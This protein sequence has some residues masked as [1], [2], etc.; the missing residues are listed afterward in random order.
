MWSSCSASSSFTQKNSSNKSKVWSPK[1]NSWRLRKSICLIW[2]RNLKGSM[3]QVIQYKAIGR[4]NTW[5]YQLMSTKVWNRLLI[6]QLNTTTICCSY[7]RRK[8]VSSTPIA[9]S[10]KNLENW[11]VKTNFSPSN[12]Q[13]AKYAY[14]NSNSDWMESTLLVYNFSKSWKL[15]EKSTIK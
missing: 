10:A 4:G 7:A 15:W 9:P 2:L 3:R 8:S 12:F 5:S 14:Q 6:L 11:R 1:S 13:R